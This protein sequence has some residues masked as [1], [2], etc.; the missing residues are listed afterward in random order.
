MLT[1]W[2]GHWRYKADTASKG[3][4]AL[5]GWRSLSSTCFGCSAACRPRCPPRQEPVAASGAGVRR[6]RPPI[7]RG[8]PDSPQFSLSLF[9]ALTACVVVVHCYATTSSQRPAPS[10]PIGIPAAESLSVETHDGL[11]LA[12]WRYATQGPRPRARVVIVH[13]YAEHAGRYERLVAFLVAAGYECELVDLRGHGRS[14]GSRGHVDRFADY[15][16]D[17][18]RVVRRGDAARR[19]A[20]GVR[21]L[22]EGP[23][24]SCPL[25]VVG[26]SLGG[27]VALEYAR[28]RPGVF[29][30]LA[31]SSP[32]LAP[33]FKLPALVEKLAS[34]A[35]RVVPQRMVKSKIEP[36]SLTHDASVAQ[37]YSND[38][39]VFDTVT[40]AWWREVRRVQE[41]L[42][43]RAGKI[44]LP[45]LFLLGM[46]TGW[47]T[48]GGRRRSSS[49][50]A[51]P[52]NA[53]RCTRGSATRS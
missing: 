33:T 15:L 11:S 52:T 25:F 4:G 29:V 5:S 20:V 30:G 40:L 44:R 6:D 28:L 27:L 8:R 37:A 17:L 3:D 10:D 18:N 36:S 41:E 45:V 43:E 38:P 13:G 42:F 31:V 12:V 26:H 50:S 24:S 21:P 34:L 19:H 16:D 48:G 53:S 51:A 7:G 2:L 35:S 23:I 14:G 1:Q 47:L 9:V 22:S 39:L 49:V 46:P 32:F